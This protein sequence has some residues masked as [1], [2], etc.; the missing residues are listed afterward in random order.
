MPIRMAKLPIRMAILF[1]VKVS[2]QMSG[3]PIRA[4]TEVNAK[5]ALRVTKAGGTPTAPKVWEEL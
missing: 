1:P 3:P 5:P 2:L 4:F